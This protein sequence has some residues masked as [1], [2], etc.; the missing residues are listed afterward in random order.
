MISATEKN[1]AKSRDVWLD[2]DDIAILYM[3]TREIICSLGTFE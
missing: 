1:R 2:V 3:V